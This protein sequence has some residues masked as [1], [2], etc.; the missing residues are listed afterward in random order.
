MQKRK[1]TFINVFIFVTCKREKQP[2]KSQKKKKKKKKLKKKK[3]KK[4]TEKRKTGT[5]HGQ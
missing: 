2:V 5:R 3:K 1:R 4:K